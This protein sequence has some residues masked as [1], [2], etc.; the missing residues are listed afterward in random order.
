VAR[1]DSAG[2]HRAEYREK[3]SRTL[4]DYSEEHHRV[5]SFLD[6]FLL[7]CLPYLVVLLGDSIGL[8][9]Q[10]PNLL[11]IDSFVE[12]RGRHS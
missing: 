1:E 12:R 2:S 9:S 4:A 10:L 8:Y 11:S 5:L 3:C 7:L 6:C